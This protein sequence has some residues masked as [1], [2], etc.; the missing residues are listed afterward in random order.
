MNSSASLLPRILA[1]ALLCGAAP[2]FAA[3]VIADFDGG[4][5]NTAVDGYKGAAGDGWKGAWSIGGTRVAASSATV[6]TTSPV[7]GGGNY[8]SA[9]I[10][11]ASETGS[12]NQQGFVQRQLD[13]T[14]LDLSQPITISFDL[15]I[16]TAPG[17]NQVYSIFGSTDGNKGTGP[18]NTWTLSG[19][20]T[21]AG[22][23][24]GSEASNIAVTA[25]VTYSFTLQLDPTTHTFVGSVTDGTDSYTSS[26]L[27]FRN[28]TST[29]IG[30]Y[31]NWGARLNTG[32]TT[33]TSLSFA[34]D[35]I[36]ISSIPEPSTCALL[37]GVCGLALGLASTLR[38]RR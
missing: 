24:F 2:V 7:N 34:L 11:T 5:S 13:P 15:R 36:A 27:A 26:A 14:F 1:V 10:K 25:G 33:T 9:T 8:L 19:G 16:D 20:N 22:W 18:G 23:S 3:T 6:T 32:G 12:G 4:N 31:I 30:Q 28:S 37:A 21:S 29:D 38:R 17:A 35:N